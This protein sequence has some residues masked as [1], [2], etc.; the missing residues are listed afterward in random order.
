MSE[1]VYCHNYDCKN[2]ACEHNPVHLP[3]Q[4][5]AP[6]KAFTECDNYKAFLKEIA[7]REKAE[8]HEE[9]RREAH[10]LDGGISLKAKGNN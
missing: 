3:I 5:K 6:F 4:T 7:A 9:V 1:I 10:D 8:W 2:A